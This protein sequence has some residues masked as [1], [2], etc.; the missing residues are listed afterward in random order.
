[1][2]NKKIK[3]EVKA[4]HLLLVALISYGLAYLIGGIIGDSLGVLGLICLLLGIVNLI[5]ELSNKKRVK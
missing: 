5:K 4:K 1:M 3:K 2:E